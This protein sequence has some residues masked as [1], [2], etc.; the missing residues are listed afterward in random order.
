MLSIE[1]YS[2]AIGAFYSKMNCP[3]KIKVVAGFDSSNFKKL[4]KL[5]CSTAYFL[6]PIVFYVTFLLNLHYS[7]V[8]AGNL[9]REGVE[10][11]PGLRNFAI[12]KVVQESHH[13]GDMRYG[14]D[15]AG[16]QCTANAHFAIVFSAIK[17]VRLWK[18]FD[19][20]NVLE[21]GDKIFKDVCNARG[22]LEAL[23]NDELP[24]NLQIE[25]ASISVTRLALESNLFSERNNLFENYIHYSPSEKGN[26]AI[27]TCA[28]Y[29][30]ATIWSNNDVFIFDSHSHNTKICMI[31]MPE[32]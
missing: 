32:Q 30:I 5:I 21:Q 9:A 27:F 26:G 1:A 13:Q 12:N 25:G 14:E 17:S 31:Q 15:S 4:H 18:S 6:C 3:R 16:R 28:G 24:L 11:N 8:K 23:V 7:L 19:L 29:S 10:T 20:D 22:V 2:A